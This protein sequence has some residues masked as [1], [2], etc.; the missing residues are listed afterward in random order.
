M[1]VKELRKHL[2]KFPKDCEVYISIDT[3]SAIGESR[4]NLRGDTEGGRVNVI[5]VFGYPEFIEMN[6]INP[7]QTMVAIYCDYEGIGW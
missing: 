7:P 4:D 1:T 6:S 5:R 2:K 3:D